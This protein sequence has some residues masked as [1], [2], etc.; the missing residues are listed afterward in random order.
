MRQGDDVRAAY[1]IHR[2]NK[3]AD[4]LLC[5]SQTQKKHFAGS[6]SLE[7]LNDKSRLTD[8]FFRQHTNDMLIRLID[9][10]YGKPIFG[11]ALMLLCIYL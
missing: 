4:M 2:E 11:I 7:P 1:V 5:F 8:V 3:G 10:T 9:I 6:G